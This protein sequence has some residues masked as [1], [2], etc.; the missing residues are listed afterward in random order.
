MFKSQ[1][2]HDVTITEI[3]FAESRFNSDDPNAF[4]ICVKVETKSEPKQSDYW[5]GECSGRYGK[6]NFAGKT[7]YQI[8]L[9]NLRKLGFQG[10]DLT[11]LDDQLV[12]KTA[13]AVVESREYEGKTYYDVKYLNGTYRPEAMST[14]AVKTRIAALNK[15]GGGGGDAGKVAGGAKK[16]EDDVVF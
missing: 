13:T 9:E 6:G 5:R 8:T 16:E 12:G 3:L 1:G 7:Q 11:K 15:M 4:D 2:N 10:D 14:D